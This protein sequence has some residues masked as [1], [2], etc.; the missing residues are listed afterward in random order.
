MAPMTRDAVCNRIRAELE[1]VFPEA[2]AFEPATVDD[3][4]L[5]IVAIGDALDD[6]REQ[7]ACTERA[8]VRTA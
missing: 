1:A 8:E 2:S 5:L 6:V 4:D 7:L 3:V